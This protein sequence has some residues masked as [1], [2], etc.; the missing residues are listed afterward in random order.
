MSSQIE[1]AISEQG[2]VSGEISENINNVR[3]ASEQVIAQSSSTDTMLSRLAG[4]ADEQQ[5]LV[6]QF[7]V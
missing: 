6:A 4:L 5:S 1:S 3:K 7:R 2:K